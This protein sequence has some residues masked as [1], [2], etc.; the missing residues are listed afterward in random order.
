M[1]VEIYGKIIDV[2]EKGFYI[3]EINE[4][5]QIL[6]SNSYFEYDKVKLL[7]INLYS[8]NKEKF[9]NKYSKL[10]FKLLELFC[11]LIFNIFFLISDLFTRIY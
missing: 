5:F 3:K 8:T 1:K 6:S 2:Q 4:G 10:I 11:F 7:T 9:F